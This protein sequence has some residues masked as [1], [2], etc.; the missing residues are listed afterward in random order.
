M[1]AREALLT[2]PGDEQKPGESYVQELL[3]VHDMIRRD[4]VA[5]RRL[6]A[7]A[8][9][10]APPED[11]SAEI[12]SLQTKGPL[13]KPR[14]NCMH[15]CRFV[16]GHHSLEDQAMF[17]PYWSRTPNS[18]RCSTSLKADHREIAVY[19]DE[20]AESIGEL[21][22]DETPSSRQRLAAALDRLSEHLLVHLD[23]EEEALSPPRSDRGRG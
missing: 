20:I 11:L 1:V 15:Y 13:W 3:W 7:D 10:G 12:E 19:L 9:D 17:R 6:A 2:N 22:W 4:L 5:V 23:Y 8:L 16:H 21:Q 18:R 14:M